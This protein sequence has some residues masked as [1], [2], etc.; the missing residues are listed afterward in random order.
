MDDKKEK[1]MEILNR[2]EASKL[3]KKP[4]K[5]KIII[6]IAVVLAVLAGLGVFFATRNTEKP[7]LVSLGS[8]ETA[9]IEETVTIR[10]AIQGSESADVSS[11]LNYKITAVYV[12]EGDPVKKDQVLA[13]L[14]VKDLQDQYNKAS[15]ALRES[16]RAYETAETLYNEGA[17]PRD[18][19]L[20][21]KAAYESDMLNLSSFDIADKKNIKSPINGTVTRVNVT[22][23]RYASDT[24]RGQAMFV[25]ENLEDLQMKVRVSEY[26]ISKI[27][28]GQTVTVTAEVLGH[29]SVS[30]LVSSISPTGEEKDVTSSEK[31]IP[32]VIDIDKGDKNLIAG[33][34]AKATILIDRKENATVV[35]LDAVMQDPETGEDIIF[36]CEDEML[37]RLPVTLGLETNI[38]VEVKNGGVKAG[39]MVVLAP[40]FDLEDGMKVSVIPVL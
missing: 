30:G 25:I 19:Y 6:S 34:T 28:V 11:A 17:M 9:D 14:D 38:S 8:V 2:S 27:K 40:T 4:S 1:M 12:R 21:L 36:I 26:D 29:E 16:A 7:A 5:I 20:R 22:V 13:T 3:S 23:G 39:D 24:E 35:S 15:L 31:V 33:V 32:V 37:R 10:G 18:D